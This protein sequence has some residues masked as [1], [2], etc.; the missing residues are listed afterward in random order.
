[1][2]NWTEEQ[3]SAIEANGSGII[4]S[5]AAGSGKT[6][7][8]I[9]R[10]IRI[11]CDDENKIPADKLLA[12]T[13]TKDAASQLLE[14]LT[15]A[16]NAEIEKSPENKWVLEQQLN[17]SRA[18]IATI[19]AFCFE[20]VKNNI[21]KFEFSS[22][23]RILDDVEKDTLL[24]NSLDEVFEYFYKEFP[25]VMMD[26]F[27]AFCKDNDKTLVNYV[28]KLYDFSR[29]LPFKKQYFDKLLSGYY[30]DS[31]LYEKWINILKENFYDEFY[32]AYDKV[33]ECFDIA[34]ELEIYEK[35]ADIIK[36]DF[37]N[38]DEVKVL[39]EKDDFNTAFSTLKKIKFANFYSKPSLS[40]KDKYGDEIDDDTKDEYQDSVLD[41]KDLVE[42]L[43]VMRK[44]FK[45]IVD[46]I[47]KSFDFDEK[48]LEAD[49]EENRNALENLLLIVAKLEEIVWEK[50]VEKNAVDFSDVELMTVQ[51]LSEESENGIVRSELCEKLLADERY[52]IILIDEFQDVNNLQDTI[53]KLLS[54]G[55][56]FDFIGENVFVVG[57]VKQSIYK[58]RQA[59]PYIFLRNK[60]FAEMEEN[61][62]VLSQICLKRNF[63]SRKNIIDFTNFIFSQIMSEK[64]GE[65]EYNDDEKLVLGADFQGKNH[66]TDILLCNEE[67]EYQAIALQIKKMLEEGVP[68]F[69]NGSFRPCRQGDFCVLIRGKKQAK[70]I[71]KALKTVNLSS[72]SEE[73]TGYL[74]SPEISLLINILTIIENPFQE[75]PLISVLYSPI[76]AF[77]DDDLAILKIRFPEE[78]LY[79]TLIVYWQT[80]EDDVLKKKCGRFLEAIKE[81]RIFA[82]ACSL[83]ML[84]RKIYDSTDIISLISLYK[85]AEQKRANLRLLIEYASSFDEAIGGG[86]AMFLRYIKRVFEMKKDFK[87]AGI[88]SENANSISVKT[89][90]KS[91]GLEFP[92][93]ILCGLSGEF[94]GLK[95]D[96]QNS[97]QINEN[98]GMGFKFKDQNTLIKYSTLAFS[99]IQMQNKIELLSEEMRLLYVALTRAKEK[100]IIAFSLS[101]KQKQRYFSFA[102][103]IAKS[104]KITPFIAQKA[105]TLQDWLFMSLLLFNSNNPIKKMYAE[106]YENIDFS[107]ESECNINF[108]NFLQ[109]EILKE[110]NL[111]EN[112]LKT[113][114]NIVADEDL[115]NIILEKLR[116]KCENKQSF[117]AAKLSVSEIA[118]NSEAVL[119]NDFNE[120][121]LDFSLLIDDIG[122]KNG[123]SP[124]QKGT[125]IHS[126]MQLADFNF[127]KKDVEKEIQR[128]FLLGNLSQKQVDCM[129]RKVIKNFFESKFYER[130]QASKNV[131]REKQFLVMIDELDLSAFDEKET[132]FLMTYKNTEGMLQGVADCVFEEDDGYVLIDYKTD[133]VASLKN[134]KYKYENQLK[135]YKASLD[136][137]LDKP[138]KEAF[139]YSFYLSDGINISL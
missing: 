131:F 104:R 40:F 122:Q 11:L 6:A 134:L 67:N 53:F 62:E 108:Y 85:D 99:A 52:E 93:V 78:K 41:E 61:S 124:A 79:N 119:S 58:F 42:K 126:F 43:K 74:R 80:G 110:S 9:E 59:N 101:D 75:I 19:N 45:D 22:G 48:Y 65:V 32:V 112:S 28:M 121:D 39:C 54:K 20:I 125:A 49:L 21:N 130:I 25:E 123:L 103:L 69:D 1:M 89:I 116:K 15:N 73:I 2:P 91:K 13:F 8:L 24:Q 129:D 115:F 38:M 33:K 88:T 90:H 7:V 127:A 26:L 96:I 117:M 47:K 36:N 71:S 44:E 23:I 66:T 81:L 107:V 118:K 16:L 111:F 10:T 102:N 133:R 100:L 46:K 37:I 55:E 139:I 105:V 76:F 138:I 82:T 137:I 31:E 70:E 5:A 94:S 35:T 56:N 113:K 95:L 30:K 60:K 27:N 83:E 136:I 4:V 72:S 98:F 92:F 135:L 18:K 63:R 3:L 128:L 120:D 34:I 57:D 86:T 132:K 106:Q 29:S 51:L 114:E 50:K 12:V 77:L 14:K 109:D 97:F 87:Q 84:I 17:L 68:V 64:V